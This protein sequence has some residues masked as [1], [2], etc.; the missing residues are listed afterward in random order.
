MFIIFLQLLNSP[1]QERPGPVPPT[2]KKAY[3]WRFPSHTPLIEHGLLFFK[4][5]PS[6]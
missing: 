5:A 1:K 3:F 2:W 4:E 6:L